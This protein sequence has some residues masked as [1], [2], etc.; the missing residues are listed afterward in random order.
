MLLIAND[1]SESRRI[2]RLLRD[3]ALWR[4]ES[5]RSD[6]RLDVPGD[7]EKPKIDVI[8]LALEPDA[9][10]GPRI[11]E[12][13]RAT[14]TLTPII[15]ICAA[16]EEA[17]AEKAMAAGAQDFLVLKKFDGV[18]LTR[19]IRWAI[20][21]K[22]TQE[23]LVRSQARFRAIVEAIPDAVVIFAADGKIIF[24]SPAT[25]TILGYELDE[26]VGRDAAELLAPDAREYFRERLEESLRRPK[27]PI[28]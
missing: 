5:E 7:H 26:F 23:E 6:L 18:L 20:E 8:L 2:Q 24:G 21:R 4:V 12:W 28:R 11:L 1:Q 13:I 22:G 17:L 15:V 10:S 14:S 3:P 27:E 25:R 16:G 19:V 9:S